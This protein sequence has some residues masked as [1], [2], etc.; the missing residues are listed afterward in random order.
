L[1]SDG[2]GGDLIDDPPKRVAATPW[3][4]P[5]SSFERRVTADQGGVRF[6]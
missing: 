1:A 2:D 5:I 4:R 3:L 6:G